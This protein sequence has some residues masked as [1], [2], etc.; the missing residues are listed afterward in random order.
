MKRS[1]KCVFC[2]QNLSKEKYH[3]DYILVV[4]ADCTHDP[5]SM[6]KE[7]KPVHKKCLLKFLIYNQDKFQALL[8]EPL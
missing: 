5:E 1:L 8:N 7:A 6:T 4:V 3:E 2:G